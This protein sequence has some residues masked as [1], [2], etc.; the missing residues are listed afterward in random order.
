LYTLVE[1]YF[2]QIEKIN[3]VNSNVGEINPYKSSLVPKVLINCLI[4]SLS[5]DP[6]VLPPV[7]NQ[8]N[9]LDHKTKLT[10]KMAAFIVMKTMKQRKVI[11][12]KDKMVIKKSDKYR[13]KMKEC[14]KKILKLAPQIEGRSRKIDDEVKE[15]SI[16]ND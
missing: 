16:L 6:T 12:Y 10:F 14:E 13:E 9:K 11:L 15:I 5:K 1:N 8:I 4:N 2:K 3:G 7:K